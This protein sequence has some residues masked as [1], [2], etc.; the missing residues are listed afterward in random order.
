MFRVRP[1][2]DSRSLCL[3]GWKSLQPDWVCVD[4][5]SS[6]RLRSAGLGGRKSPAL[7]LVADSFGVRFAFRTDSSD[8]ESCA[9]ALAPSR[10]GP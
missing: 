5:E 2:I 10:R 1:V 8:P 6:A 4:H 7:V 3:V 9:N